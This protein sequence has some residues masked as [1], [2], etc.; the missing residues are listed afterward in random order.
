VLVKIEAAPCNP[1]D[2]MYMRGRYGITKRPPT[3]PGFEGAGTVVASGGGLLGS[4][5]KGKRVAC[6]GQSDADGTWAEYFLAEAGFCI[7]LRAALPF[8]QGAMMIAN[9]ITALVLFD[10][11]R[12]GGH[13]AAIHSAGA[14]QLGRMLTRLAAEAGYPLI[15]LVRRD[16]LIAPLKQ[17]GAQIVLN[18][19]SPGFDEELRKHATELGATIVLDAVSGPMLRRVMKAMPLRSRAI[20]Y[21]SLSESDAPLDPHDLIFREQ[22]VEGFWLSTWIANKSLFTKMRLSNQVQ[23]RIAAGTFGSEVRARLKLADVRSGLLDY[24]RHM[25][26]GKI[27]ICPGLR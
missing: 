22:S 7:P 15:N 2:L 1:S 6:G 19:T 11:C 13:R 24:Q 20:V 12:K 14:S 10:L 23:K 21:G 9:P 4:F 16:E 18:M 3:V 17:L 25:S 5:L 27:L 8:D 26:E